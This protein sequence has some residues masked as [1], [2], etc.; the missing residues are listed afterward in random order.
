MAKKQNPQILSPE[1]Y[2]RQRARNL[3]IF[4]CYI[5][6]GWDEGGLAQVTI[7]RR[8]VNGNITYCSYLVDLHCLGIKDTLFDFNIP[9]EHFNQVVDRMSEEYELV[10]TDYALV[11]NIIYAGWEFAEEIGFKPHKDFLSTTQYMLDED[12]E[13][14]PII[15][16]H[17]GDKDGIPLYV[18][19]PFEDDAIANRI[20]SQLEKKLGAGNFHYILKVDSLPSDD[21]DEEEE[22]EEDKEDDEEEL[23]E[24][25]DD[26]PFGGID[27]EDEEDDDD[28]DWEEDAGMIFYREY[29]RYSYEENA[30]LFLALS[31]YLDEVKWD[32]E[33]A[34][35]DDEQ[36]EN[37]TRLIAL[38]V[39]LSQEIIQEEELEKWLD[40]WSD[41]SLRYSVTDDSLYEMLGLPDKSSLTPKDIAYIRRESDSGKLYKY[42]L[43]R[44]GDL[45]YLYTM[46]IQEM[47]DSLFRNEEIAAA[48]L[49]FPDYGLIK[50]LDMMNRTPEG[51][52][53]EE[54]LL[55]E[56]VFGNRKEITPLEYVCLQAMRLD[57]FVSKKNFAGVESIYFMVDDQFA[58]ENQDEQ[59]GTFL[60]IILATRISMLRSYLKNHTFFDQQG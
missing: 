49:K 21:W 8:H 9:E 33:E 6:E 12:N 14:I 31:Q 53:K 28:E 10:E 26:L 25:D 48:R 51:C 35:Y 16:I 42:L 36:D 23:D 34:E 2:I 5:N 22:E 15:E 17:C 55:Y 30:R 19:G 52:I 29:A 59:I 37:L 18:Q 40:R 11:H 57:Y 1:N 4:K 3:P 45:P 46:K 24:D 43:K 39:L 50:L 38:S 20:M 44:W 32:Q 58:D 41:E 54:E 56:S 13:T 47:E 27:W 7:A 60:S